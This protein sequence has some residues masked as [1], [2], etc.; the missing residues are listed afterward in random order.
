MGHASRRERLE[1]DLRNLKSQN[2]PV[3][4][5]LLSRCHC[6]DTMD[7]ANVIIATELKSQRFDQDG[8]KTLEQYEESVVVYK[9][10]ILHDQDIIDP[11]IGHFSVFSQLA[12]YD[13]S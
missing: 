10:I 8:C 9:N 3:L 2:G 5:I 4:K 1:V 6:V 7:E 11:D 13:Q 12:L